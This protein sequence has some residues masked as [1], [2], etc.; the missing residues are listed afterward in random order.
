M[1]S[2]ICREINLK[3][4]NTEG[5]EYPLFLRERKKENPKTM[6]THLY[7]FFTSNYGVVPLLY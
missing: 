7:I 5:N 3:I 4:P 1:E 2:N 6:Y